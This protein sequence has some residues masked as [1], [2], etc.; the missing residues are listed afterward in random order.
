MNNLTENQI[1]NNKRVKKIEI[2]KLIR[3]K[4]FWC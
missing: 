4:V 2:L 3:R 1:K